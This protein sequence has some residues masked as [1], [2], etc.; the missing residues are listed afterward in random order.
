MNLVHNI[1]QELYGANGV[2]FI[3]QREVAL[4]LAGYLYTKLEFQKVCSGL[5]IRDSEDKFVCNLLHSAIK[6]K[7]VERSV[8]ETLF[9]EQIVNKL[10]EE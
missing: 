6:R 4:I 9:E 1:L 8:I 3:S 2:V 7:L 10:Y 5:N